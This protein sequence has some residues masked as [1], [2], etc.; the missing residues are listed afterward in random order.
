[1]PLLVAGRYRCE[2]LLGQG[3]AARVFRARDQ[4]LDRSVA[5]KLLDSKGAVADPARFQEEARVLARLDHPHIVP[6]LDFGVHEAIPFLVLELE[7]GGTLEDAV[8]R[9]VI[10]DARAEEV[11]R[12]VLA[13]LKHA[14]DQGFLHRDIKPGNV[15]LARDGTAGEHS[16][17]HV[18]EVRGRRLAAPGDSG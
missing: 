3:S 12:Q 13:G 6:V 14:H 7:E 9:G 16:S 17:I 11:S 5:V 2:L 4:T 18:E 1:M 15:L 10:D 8:V